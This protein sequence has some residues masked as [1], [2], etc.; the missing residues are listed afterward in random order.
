MC[1]YIYEH[2]CAG[3]C[4]GKMRMQDPLGAEITGGCE[5]HKVDA[6]N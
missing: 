3:D 2:I 6:E 4:K 1:S 5:P